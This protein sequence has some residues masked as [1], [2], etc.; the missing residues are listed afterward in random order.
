MALTA[1]LDALIEG[2]DN[3]RLIGDQIAAILAVESAGQQVIATAESKDPLL[4]KLRVFRERV[5]PFAEWLEASPEDAPAVVHPPIINVA[6]ND[7]TDDAAV[8]TSVE[9][10]KFDATYNIDCYG[11]GVAAAQYDGGHLPGDEAAANEADRAATLVRRIL[12]AA[13]YTYL[14]L[15]G[16]VWRRRIL[17]VTAFD[18]ESDGRTV[19]QV[20]AVRLVLGC[21]FNELSPQ[22][23]PQDTLAEI[24]ATVHRGETGE[25]YLRAQFG[26][27][28]DS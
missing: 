23:P 17:S 28:N 3:R 22:H 4:W 15:Q 18:P 6:F 2:V 10:Q 8:G 24:L 7:G 11:Y 14:G 9:S 16:T 19:Q 20:S 1:Q 27:D 13:H 26:E 12:M 5:N 21:M 25:I